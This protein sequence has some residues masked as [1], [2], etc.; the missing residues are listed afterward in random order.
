MLGAVPRLFVAFTP[1]GEA[2]DEASRIASSL[3]PR[4]GAIVPKANLHMTLAFLGER[5]DVPEIAGA[6]RLAGER[7]APVTVELS[8]IG[9]FPSSGRAR[10]LYVGVADPTGRLAENVQILL[11]GLAREPVRWTSERPFVPHITICRLRGA[12]IAIDAF[13]VRRVAFE[14]TSVDLFESVLRQPGPPSYALI[15]SAPF[16]RSAGSSQAG[17]CP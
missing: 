9:G 1:S 17:G 15:A 7:C 3:D 11:G 5:S 16:A 4:L 13:R 14:I 2:A 8:E 12:P 10:T 6:L